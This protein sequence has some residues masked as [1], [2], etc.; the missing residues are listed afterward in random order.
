MNFKGD[1]YGVITKKGAKD[2]ITELQSYFNNSSNVFYD[3]G[4]ANGDLLL[5]VNEMTNLKSITGIELHKERYENSLKKIT[6]SPRI[7]LINK[8]FIQ[9][10]LS[11]ANIVYLDNTAIPKDI[12]NQLF[13]NLP[14]DCLLIACRRIKC[15]YM[16]DYKKT[17][18]IEKDYA[19]SYSNWYITIK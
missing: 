2:L 10:D 12:C 14:K 6:N 8:D 17:N 16:S 5:Y 18:P 1:T 3:L 19:K 15:S 7:S 4:S 9:V 13:Q 11:N